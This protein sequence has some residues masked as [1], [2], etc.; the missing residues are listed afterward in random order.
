LGRLTQ[1]VTSTG[2]AGAGVISTRGAAPPHSTVG[3]GAV[4][5][6]EAMTKASA[7]MIKFSMLDPPTAL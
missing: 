7:A 3:R 1:T 6:S 2:V 5:G 4:E